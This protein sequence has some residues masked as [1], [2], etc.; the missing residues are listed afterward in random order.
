MNKK[1]VSFLNKKISIQNIY[2]V[3]RNYALHAKELGNAIPKEPVIFLKPNS[4]IIFSEDYIELPKNSQD[5]HHE[6]EI[7]LLIGKNK[8][9]EGLGIGI[10]VTARDIQ[11]KLKNEKLPWALAKG[12]RTFAPV[13]D[14]ISY[15]AV[16]QPIE[17]SLSIN[18]S[19][20]QIGSSKDMIFSFEFLVYFLEERF[21]LMEGDLIFTGTPSGVGKINAGDE[22]LAQIKGTELELRVYAR[23][24]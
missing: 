23:Q 24:A 4:S 3:G 2:C 21:G 16:K 17:F 9:I 15:E 7:V 5:V 14:F 18:G 22:L 13:S 6:V 10:D 1:E 20:K 19:Q 8:K 11:E 12:L